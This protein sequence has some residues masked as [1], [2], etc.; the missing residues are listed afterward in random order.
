MVWPCFT[1]A[2]LLV[3]AVD[4]LWAV[5]DVFVDQLSVLPVLAQAVGPQKHQQRPTQLQV[6]DQQTHKRTIELSGSPPL[7]PRLARVLG[8]SP[9]PNLLSSFS[10]PYR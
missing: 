9:S 8:S 7:P 1:C 5:V 10:L 6:L 2:V 3:L 4:A